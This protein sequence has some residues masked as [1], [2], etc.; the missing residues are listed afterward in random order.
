M[1]KGGF[2]I[3]DPAATWAAA[4]LA[5]LLSFLAAIPPLSGAS[6]DRPAGFVAQ[7]R[8]QC[9]TL[10]RDLQLGLISD[11][12]ALLGHPSLPKLCSQHTWML[13]W[14][15]ARQGLRHFYKPPV[16]RTPFPSMRA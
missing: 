5:S 12:A 9:P 6:C 15:E 7:L 14:E 11:A 2:G 3:Q 1:Q 8:S 16:G 10:S 4:S 13:E